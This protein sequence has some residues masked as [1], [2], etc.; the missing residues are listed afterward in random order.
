MAKRL[1][2]AQVFMVLLLVAAAAPSLLFAQGGETPIRIPPALTGR[3]G[4]VL[5]GIARG[6][7]YK[8]TVKPDKG[9]ALEDSIKAGQAGLPDSL[10]GVW[11]FSM[12]RPSDKNYVMGLASIK[13]NGAK[14]YCL[15]HSSDFGASWTVTEPPALADT[16]FTVTTSF[17]LQGLGKM[18]WLD[19]GMHGWI[20]GKKGIVATTDGGATWQV[21]LRTVAS[22]QEG[23]NEG[24]WALAFRDAQN[25]VATIGIPA[26]MKF[27][28]TA[29]GGASWTPSTGSAP[30][31]LRVVQVDWV[32]NEYR[33]FCF[34]RN[35]LSSN[36]WF[37]FSTDGGTSWGTQA[38][39]IPG[40]AREQSYMSELIWVGHQQGFM[41][42]RSGDIFRTDY[43]VIPP[44]PQYAGNNWTKI[45]V[46]DSA[47]YPI[48]V[49]PGSGWGQ[50]TIWMKDQAG[51]DIL[52]HA[53]TLR[54]DGNL[55]RL[56]AWGIELLA[57]APIDPTFTEELHLSAYPN[58]AIGTSELQFQLSAPEAGI[59]VVVDPLGREVLR[60]DLGLMNAGQQRVAL[61]V[62]TLPAGMYRY[63]LQL[64]ERRAGGAVVVAR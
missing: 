33:A 34:D 46:A 10:D 55:Y 63:V 3:D 28:R 11:Y 49:G 56:L 16:Q 13:N 50:K 4:K 8:S 9:L 42:L 31:L 17:W 40:I 43:K 48:P 45:Q 36:G 35:Q 32:N 37:Y 14:K 59:V 21:Q 6:V 60:R 62:A 53:S 23:Y 1:R 57:S 2:S 7:I 61:D 54:A 5:L 22:T 27:Q 15:I 18:L 44:N 24:V 51:N 38:K 39:R 29:N 58:P 20:Y 12:P 19:D 47:A 41:V 26:N 30:E 25:G 52:V 64:G